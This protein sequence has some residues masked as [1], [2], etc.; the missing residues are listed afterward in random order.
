MCNARSECRAS[1]RRRKANALDLAQARRARPAELKDLTVRRKRCSHRPAHS[2]ERIGSIGR[3]QKRGVLRHV[4]DALAT[5]R[6][7][8]LLRDFELGSAVSAED[9][10]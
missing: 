5:A 9:L 2:A 1:Y 7:A 4:R 3:G 8:I 6:N 10:L